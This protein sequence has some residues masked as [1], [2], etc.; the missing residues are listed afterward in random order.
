MGSV[1]II[2]HDTTT[3]GNICNRHL[4]RT[5]THAKQ[6]LSARILLFCYYKPSCEHA[7]A[8]LEGLYDSLGYHLWVLILREDCKIKFHC[9]ETT[10]YRNPDNKFFAM[11]SDSVE[12]NRSDSPITCRPF[13]FGMLPIT[14]CRMRVHFW[15]L[16]KKIWSAVLSQYWCVDRGFQR[17]SICLWLYIF[18]K[19]SAITIP[20]LYVSSAH[21]TATLHHIFNSLYD[22]R[23]DKLCNSM[24][25]RSWIT[26]LVSK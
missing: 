3:L 23:L 6:V 10:L 4:I 20:I 26:H 19:Y 11:I 2:R 13:P 22:I 14:W 8:L 5:G 12:Y 18:V 25:R 1:A 16:S 7:V 24:S 21:P 9:L 17:L 15:N